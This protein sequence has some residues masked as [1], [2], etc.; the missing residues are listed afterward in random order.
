MSTENYRK[1]RC[2]TCDTLY[3][4]ALGAPMDGIAPGTRW[5]E[6]PDDWTCP[7]CSASKDD[8]FLVED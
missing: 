7:E 4:E 5:E 3:D 2:I 6:V 1:Y 8:F